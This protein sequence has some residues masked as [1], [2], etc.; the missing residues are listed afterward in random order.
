MKRLI[1]IVVAYTFLTAGLH[2]ADISVEASL[3]RNKGYVGDKINYS[4]KIS[5]DTLVTIDTISV[6]ESFG[7]FE[8]R[9]WYMKSDTIDSGLRT[10]EYSAI[11]TVYKTGKV[12][13]PALPVVYKTGENDIDTIYSDSIDVYILSLV[14]DDSTADIRSLKD[15]KNFGNQ[16]AWLYYIIPI[17]VV[18]LILVIWFILRKKP[19]IEAAR[20]APLKSPWEAARERL[21]KLKNSD[22]EPKPYYIELSDAIREYL[23]RRYG[24]SA[25]DMTT[26]E[27]RQEIPHLNF[28]DDLESRLLDLLDN[29]D[30]VK[31]AKFKPEADFLADDFQRAWSFIDSTAPGK[32]VTD[33]V[34]V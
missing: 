27:I 24:F 6:P 30:L 28:D 11:A 8:L 12:V 16:Y 1:Y 23:Q 4:L 29:S 9:N 10:I 20:S 19:Q 14:L 2:A 17:A 13:I 34:R 7:E 31:F 3:D 33:E 32:A 21:M 22:L 15:V 25:L 5:A 18:A 26:F